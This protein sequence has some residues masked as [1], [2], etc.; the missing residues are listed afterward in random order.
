MEIICEWENICR[1]LQRN[2]GLFFPGLHLLPDQPN[3]LGTRSVC[4]VVGEGRSAM[5]VPIPIYA[6]SIVSVHEVQENDLH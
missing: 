5:A 3:R 2:L 1:A 4:R 6:I